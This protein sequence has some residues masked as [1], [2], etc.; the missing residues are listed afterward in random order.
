MMI[1]SLL[2]TFGCLMIF[3]VPDLSTRAVM[4]C[5][6]L[7]QFQ[8]VAA[9][10]CCSGT[11]V[12]RLQGQEQHGADLQTFVSFGIEAGGLVGNIV[13]GGVVQGLGPRAAWGLAALPA[14]AVGS[15]A[16][17]GFF[18][19][20][21]VSREALARTRQSIVEQ[22]EVTFLAFVLFGCTLFT[23]TLSV[24]FANLE[25]NLISYLV[26]AALVLFC[27]SA[28]L[29][30]PI[31]R[32][33]V[34]SLLVNAASLNID[35]AMFYFL[36][37]TTTMNEDGP[38]LSVMFFNSVRGPVVGIF[39]LIGILTYNRFMKAWSYRKVILLGQMSYSAT[40]L[41][42]LIIVTR[43]NVRLGIPDSV[44]VLVHSALRSMT[45]QWCRM[46]FR[47]LFMYLCPIGMEATMYSLLKGTSDLGN[48]VSDSLGAGLLSALGCKPNG[49]V[50][51]GESFRYLG[52]AIAITALF[53]M[54]VVVSMLPLV[55]TGEPNRRLIGD[56]SEATADSAM[57]AWLSSMHP[58]EKG[59]GAAAAG[60]AARGSGSAAAL[61]E[62]GR[63]PRTK[64][65]VHIA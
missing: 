9:T 22:R 10:V 46:P 55:P 65:S 18:E 59:Y 2:G 43:L 32:V 34:F 30:P 20:T 33:S 53:N 57:N 19:E 47:V 5:L 6:V 44:F 15:L 62:D 14:A 45:M 8:Q 51:E 11:V 39:A 48:S 24:A 54:V 35:S 17:S 42:T 49:S 56:A 16:A 61:L 29:S 63:L 50:G 64:D 28:V 52:L 23:N 40:V 31:A 12:R 38:H 13:T 58:D 21:R 25:M 1:A 41:S 37:D 7:L 3:M 36:T 27:F 4:L 60:R 26:G